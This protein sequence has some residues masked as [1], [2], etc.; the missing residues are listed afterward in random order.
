VAEITVLVALSAL[1]VAVLA[2]WVAISSQTALREVERRLRALTR[3]GQG[4]DGI[5]ILESLRER[6]TPPMVGPEPEVDAAQPTTVEPQRPVEGPDPV[7][8]TGRVEADAAP[9]LPHPMLPTGAAPSGFRARSLE[10]RLGASLP[11]WFGAVA[12]ALA[13]VFLVKHFVE[14]GLLGPGPRVGLAIAFGLCLLGLALRA[15]ARRPAIAQG[16]A[17]AGVAVLSGAVFAA[18][19]LYGFLSPV[20]GLLAQGGVT[21][22]AVVASLRLGPFVALL[23]L[24]GGFAIPALIGPGEIAAGTMFGYLAL[25]LLAL[26]GLGRRDS[27]WWVPL[28]GVVGAFAWA[29][30]WPGL[31][32]DGLSVVS[33]FAL[34]SAAVAIQTARRVRMPLGEGLP[35][36]SVGVSW[37]VSLAALAVL[38]QDLSRSDFAAE[39]WVWLGLLS[40]GALAL[41]AFERRYAGLPWIAAVVCGVRLCLVEGPAT[42]TQAWSIGG[43]A[44]LLGFGGVLSA[45]GP[46][47]HRT[48]LAWLPALVALGSGGAAEFAGLSYGWPAL[49]GAGAAMALAL[50]LRERAA[51]EGRV[52]R[53]AALWLAGLVGLGFWAF[54]TIAAEHRV[55]A[56][57]AL[58][59][60]AA[61]LCWR[62]G[63]HSLA[64][65][66]VLLTA[67][68]WWVLFADQL[69]EP[70]TRRTPFWNAPSRGLCAVTLAALATSRLMQRAAPGGRAARWQ[71]GGFVLGLALTIFV[72]NVQVFDRLEVTRGDFLAT[73]T[74]AIAWIAAGQLLFWTGPRWAVGPGRPG[75]HLSLLGL[76]ALVSFAW[77]AT[78]PLTS[79]EAVGALPLFNG[80]LLAYGGGAAL[81]LCA[82]VGWRRAG[83]PL[84]ASLAAIVAFVCGFLLVTTQVRQA[85]HGDLLIGPEPGRAEWYSYSVAWLGYGAALLAAGVHRG[86]RGLR[87]ASLLVVLAAVLKVFLSDAAHLDGLWRVLSF[88]GLGVALITLA[89]VYQRFVVADK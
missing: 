74:L 22:I 66:L 16:L 1:A 36:L 18:T 77:F 2:L 56:L 8:G 87:Y 58:P 84:R 49:V 55:L 21:A 59:V 10:A 60:A 79:R 15:R 35:E 83:A 68:G 34:L 37:L 19:A 46:N 13:G 89:W 67:A 33:G 47:A 69:A 48:A 76:G 78:N 73:S 82:A 6:R 53:E 11:I 71:Q 80:L 4:T 41:A 14:R 50:V 30:A 75:G 31:R 72:W 86:L 70:L 9:A 54:E 29:L 24:V 7:R 88:F 27:F 51:V 40:A 45:S 52:E 12:L 17:A 39:H 43:Y 5:S 20:T 63:L 44:V 23:G 42:G 28:V 61:A 26:G 32:P 64:Y 57:A 62:R 65:G 3:A 38:L 85:F 81:A 25:L